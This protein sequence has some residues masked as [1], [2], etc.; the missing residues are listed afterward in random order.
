MA[1]PWETL[2]I[3]EAPPGAESGIVYPWDVPGF[4]SPLPSGPAGLGQ[5]PAQSTEDLLRGIIG[6]QPVVGAPTQALDVDIGPAVIETGPTSLDEALQGQARLAPTPQGVTEEP[7]DLAAALQPPTP[8][9]ATITAT[10]EAAAAPLTPEQEVA[11]IEALPPEEQAARRAA[12]EQD[13]QQEFATRKAERL[14]ADREAA[15]RNLASYETATQQARTDT[16]SLIAQAKEIGQREVDPD[17]WWAS[18]ST[19]QKIA[20]FIG[21]ALSG[22]L[23]PGGKNQTLDLINQAIDRDLD[24]QVQSL[25][26]QRAALATQQ[27]LVGDMYRQTGDLLT[28][29]EGARVAVLQRLDDELGAEMAQYDPRSARVQAMADARARTRQEIA[30]GEAKI[31]ETTWKRYTEQAEI[32][33]KAA[34]I[35]QGERESRRAAATT[36]RGQDIDLAAK[37]LELAASAA[38]REAAKGAELGR[39]VVGRSVGGLVDPASG[40]PPLDPQTG[41]PHEF[42]SEGARDRVAAAKAGVEQ[43]NYLIEKMLEARYQHGWESDTAKSDAWREMQSYWADLLLIKKDLDKLGVLAGPDM[44]LLEKA[45]GTGDPTEMRDPQA[46]LETAQK[47]MINKFRKQLEAERYP[48]WREYEP[49]LPLDVQTAREDR[50][51]AR[52]EI[53]NIREF[54]A[55]AAQLDRSYETHRGMGGT[56]TKEQW[57]QNERARVLKLQEDIE[58]ERRKYRPFGWPGR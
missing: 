21:A 18:R 5:A 35:A 49:E 39:A 42:A 25:A 52:K 54:G 10:P 53:S 24:A 17:R 37:Q 15:D 36:R 8:I 16:Q 11:A 22:A 58:K 29:R 4:A 50:E 1:Y 43:A 9:T 2:P 34:R 51:A 6:E 47:S 48:L 7:A 30:A 41:M 12:R 31:A 3:E 20:G 13:L 56:D 38:E 55:T 23:A 57:L 46:G 40:L 26:G 19:G 32:D 28:A 33:D 44:S 14:R 45:I 27:G